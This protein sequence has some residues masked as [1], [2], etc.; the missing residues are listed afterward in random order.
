MAVAFDDWRLRAPCGV[1]LARIF[2]FPSSGPWLLPEGALADWLGLEVETMVDVMAE[3][4]HSGDCRSMSSMLKAYGSP[5]GAE[6]IG[7]TLFNAHALGALLRLAP[8]R[9]MASVVLEAWH[10]E[11]LPRLRPGKRHWLAM[12]DVMRLA[13]NAGGGIFGGAC[14]DYVLRMGQAK[15]FYGMATEEEKRERYGDDSCCARTRHRN[16][17]PRDIDVVFRSR[18]LEVFLGNVRAV[19]NV[20]VSRIFTRTPRIYLGE[21]SKC[22]MSWHRYVVEWSPPSWA[23]FFRRALKYTDP[24]LTATLA[25]PLPLGCFFA[26]D[27]MVVGD[28]E[29]IRRIFSSLP[30]DFECNSLVLMGR[31]MRPSLPGGEEFL[32]RVL[33]DVAQRRAV[34]GHDFDPAGME[35]RVVKLLRSG[36]SID[37]LQGL[38]LLAHDSH[39]LCKACGTRCGAS[40]SYD[41]ACCGHSVHAACMS[42]SP[43]CP[44]CCARVPESGVAVLALVKKTLEESA[45]EEVDWIMPE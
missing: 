22:M 23:G 33:Q 28:G 13:C 20:R 43:T 6:V 11:V 27:I 21:W 4:A 3:Y 44:G 7:G 37:G 41:Y 18:D 31:E 10:H 42:L 29:D 30:V 39:A 19:L 12:R 15:E 8:R 16:V 14:R 25:S 1:A 35:R 40:V 38:R 32:E 45:L 17:L 24:K 36:W 9:A 34:L 26:M 2:I 5:H